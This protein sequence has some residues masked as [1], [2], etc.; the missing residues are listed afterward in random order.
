MAHSFVESFRSEAEAFRAFVRSYPDDAILLVDT[1]E[2]ERGLR[3][4]V[5]V[6][7]ELAAQG[8]NLRGIR[9]DSGD[10][11]ELSRRA[12]ALL[13]EAGFANAIVLVSGGLDEHD[14]DRL[15]TAGAP[16]DGFGIGSRLGTSADAPYLDMAYK[17]VEFDGRPTRKL[18]PG[19]ATLPGSKQVWRVADNHGAFAYDIVELASAPGPQGGEP[20]LQ[21]VSPG[22]VAAARERAAEQR[23]RLP[24]RHRTLAAEP[25]DVRVGQALRQLRDEL[26][27]RRV[28]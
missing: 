9:L 3:E 13:D 23:K 1:Y 21:E 15:L 16:I 25:Y 14:V 28:V 8:S 20:L 7:R 4:A 19:K 18:S 27:G 10:L 6:A 5:E 24:E 2:T 26:S 22:P 12:R 11:L 17:L